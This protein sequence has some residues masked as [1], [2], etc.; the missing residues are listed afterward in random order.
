VEAKDVAGILD[1]VEWRPEFTV[2]EAT[3][4]PP[5]PD[6]IKMVW[7]AIQL[8]GVVLLCTLGG[9]ILFASIGVWIRRRRVGPNEI[10]EPM[11]TLNLDR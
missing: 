4:A 7:A 9:G 1:S 11:I 6:S 10:D 3:K 5:A 2:N 8:A